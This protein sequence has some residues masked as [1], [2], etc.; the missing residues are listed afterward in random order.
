MTSSEIGFS[1]QF[2]GQDAATAVLPHFK[3]LQVASQGL[4]FEGFPYPELAFILRVDGE[5]NQY[6]LSGAGYLDVD[7]R[8]RYL[9]VDI[10]IERDDRGRVADVICEGLLFSMEYIRSVKPKLAK[11]IDF[12]SMEECLVELVSRYRSELTRLNVQTS[13]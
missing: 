13:S 11:K 9:S 2:G 7:R 1:A 10:G 5:V 3:A 8:G 6:E 4:R 12:R